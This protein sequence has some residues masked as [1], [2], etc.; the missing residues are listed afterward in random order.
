MSQP[1]EPPKQEQGKKSRFPK[2]PFADFIF[3]F[4]K[5]VPADFKQI[6]S[7][8]GSLLPINEEVLKKLFLEDSKIEFEEVF[9]LLSKPDQ[10]KLKD[11]EGFW[12]LNFA[13]YRHIF[14]FI[15]GI[16]LTRKDQTGQNNVTAEATTIAFNML[17]VFG[18]ANGVINYLQ[19]TIG[20]NPATVDANEILHFK[21]PETAAWDLA[22]WQKYFKSKILNNPKVKDILLPHCDKIQKDYKKSDFSKNLQHISLDELLTRCA[23]FI[24]DDAKGHEKDALIFQYYNM[25]QSHFTDWLQLKEKAQSSEILIPAKAVLTDGEH[26]RDCKDLYVCKLNDFDPRQGVLG[27]IGQNCQSMD[28]KGVI[29]ITQGVSSDAG[30]FIV[31]CRDNDRRKAEQKKSGRQEIFLGEKCKDKDIVAQAWVWLSA[32]KQHLILDT[33]EIQPVYKSPRN[34]KKIIAMLAAFTIRYLH[35]NNNCQSI[36]M[37]INLRNDYFTMFDNEDEKIIPTKNIKKYDAHKK[38]LLAKRGETLPAQL[39]ASPEYIL[40]VK[41]EE[42]IKYNL[43]NLFYIL[44][45]FGDINHMDHFLKMLTPK[46][47]ELL[48]PIYLACSHANYDFI[49]YLINY[50]EKELLKFITSDTPLLHRLLFK[51]STLTMKEK[52][53]AF[54]QMIFKNIQSEAVIERLILQQ[55]I[56]SGK[57]NENALFYAAKAGLESFKIVYES[58]S[59]DAKQRGLCRSLERQDHGCG[60]VFGSVLQGNYKDILEYILSENNPEE[61]EQLFFPEE[62]IAYPPFFFCNYEMFQFIL[63]HEKF[64]L[65]MKQRLLLDDRYGRNILCLSDQTT[66]SSLQ[67]FSYLFNKNDILTIEQQRNLLLSQQINRPYAGLNF[68]HYHVI[69][70]NQNNLEALLTYSEK[71]LSAGEL[72]ELFSAKTAAGDTVFTLATDSK[73]IEML[74]FLLTSR[75]ACET[76]YLTDANNKTP[77]ELLLDSG[78]YS[79]AEM[80]LNKMCEDKIAFILFM[81][82]NKKQIFSSLTDEKREAWIN[83]YESVI[84]KKNIKLPYE[85]YDLKLSASER[86]NSIFAKSKNMQTPTTLLSGLFNKKR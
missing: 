19:K 17:L 48:N 81:K 69:Y 74:P 63:S 22:A 29:F 11:Y 34:I 24:Y 78:N 10:E 77:L 30:G 68:I 57:S 75:H 9:S 26:I 23:S 15:K 36:S 61:I 80:V 53:A 43:E 27:H 73:S 83:L 37:G 6:E 21:L 76:L 28:K 39:I 79:A 12:K 25:Q 58:L 84:K 8:N 47:L 62:K 20:A 54:L 16:L 41:R 60:S 85:L 56:T 33:I 18:D 72:D 70:N 5:I 55:G 86:N 52:S 3:N 31:I 50:N 32:D 59:R 38:Y 42:L 45:D 65:G 82:H 2:D 71:L 44:L 35:A 49:E 14:P 7:K 13:S 46:E 40:E 1:R 64:D 67:I 66:E 4:R 51:L